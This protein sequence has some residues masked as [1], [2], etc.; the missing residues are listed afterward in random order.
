MKLDLAY[1][2]LVVISIM[3][4]AQLHLSKINYEGTDP[5]LNDIK[6]FDGRLNVLL[7]DMEYH[8]IQAQKQLAQKTF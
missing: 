3:E 4:E 1:K 8:T 6:H 2:W 5:I 7:Q